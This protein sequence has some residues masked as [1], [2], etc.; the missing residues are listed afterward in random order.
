MDYNKEIDLLIEYF[1]F[2][3]QLL[4]ECYEFGGKRIYKIDIPSFEDFKYNKS[5][6]NKPRYC[7]GYY[8]LNNKI[9][10]NYTKGL[11]SMRH[12]ATYRYYSYFRNIK[13]FINGNISGQFYINKNI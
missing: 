9:C 8:I 1:A 4:P 13:Y 12:N 2:R 10:K 11:D 3:I 6:I 7:D 5:E